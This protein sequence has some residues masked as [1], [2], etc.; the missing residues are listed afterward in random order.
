[1]N[2]CSGNAGSAA[3]TALGAGGSPL[4]GRQIR[5]DAVYGPFQIM[6]V[7]PGAPLVNSLTVVT[8][9][10]GRAVVGVQAAVNATTQPAQLRAT[11]LVTG[12]AVTGNFTV[13]NNTSSVDMTV[14]P[15]TSTIT[16]PQKGVC[17][18]GMLVDY[19]IY[20]GSPPYRVSATFPTAVT[21][22][23]PI[24]H[25]SGMNFSAVTNGTCF[26]KLVFTIM[27]SAGKQTTATMTNAEGTYEPPTPPEPA[28]MAMLPGSLTVT[29]CTGR[30]FQFIVTGGTPPYSVSTSLPGTTVAP[31]PVSQNGGTV[32]VSGITGTGTV[33][34]A[35]V[36]SSVPKKTS[37]ATITCN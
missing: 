11:D 17:S 20:G 14:V 16:G 26:D 12:Q 31:Q 27:D 15:D 5:F 3:V 30:T 18:S 1:V 2:L 29:G 34:V 19:F 36:D 35:A 25:Q 8:D 28:P 13:V 4:A 7:T 32:Q 24:V 37:T 9:A 23:N 21:V 10:A 6:G 33:T 22:L